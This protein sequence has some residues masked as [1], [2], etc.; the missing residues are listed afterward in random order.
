MIG[1]RE[2]VATSELLIDLSENRPL[3]RGSRNVR[4][5]SPRADQP[6][7]D[8]QEIVRALM[9]A[10]GFDERGRHLPLAFDRMPDQLRHPRHAPRR[11]DA[12]TAA[13]Y[14]IAD[15]DD[16]APNVLVLGTAGRRTSAVPE[17]PAL[18]VKEREVTGGRRRNARPDRSSSAAAA[19][20]TQGAAALALPEP[21]RISAPVDDQRADLRVVPR[22]VSM[23]GRRLTA[24][25][26]TLFV[27]GLLFLAV[28]MHAAL[29]QRQGQLDDT[30]V[31]VERAERDHELL[32][33]E[34]AQLESPERITAI[35]ARMGLVTP[36]RIRF[37]TPSAPLESVTRAS[38]AG[39]TGSLR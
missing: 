39:A 16:G 18:P 31:N 35:A 38:A 34:V 14:A 3:T 7:S 29:A 6:G 10:N 23:W 19:G 9:F 17:A 13:I 5:A 33:I 32:R 28:I 37:V 2:R 11:G 12:R 21:R 27:V 1:V 24:G 25:F 36:D 22:P 30:H 26:W 4:T 8:R 20:A 15:L